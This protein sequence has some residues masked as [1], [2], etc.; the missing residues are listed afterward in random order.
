MSEIETTKQVGRRTVLKGAAWSVPVVAAAAAMPLAAA[1][2]NPQCPTCLKAGVLSVVGIPLLG[3]WTSQAIVVGNKAS[4]LVVPAVGIDTST[5]VSTGFINA[6]AFTMNSA[7]LTMGDS[8]PANDVTYTQIL[9]GLAGVGTLG[10]VSAFT[11]I[12]AFLN[13]VMPNGGSIAGAYKPAPKKLQICADVFLKVDIGG[14]VGG[15][16]VTCSL[17]FEWDLAGVGTGVVLGGLAGG[18]GTINFT[19]I[20]TPA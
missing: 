18:T 12:P 11:A 6:F 15:Q 20:A 14:G 1:S 7:V 13:V 19:G 9:T 17:C 8:N 3:A 5:C 10:L 4:I 2:N 16:T